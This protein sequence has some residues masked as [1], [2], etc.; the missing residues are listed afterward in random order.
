MTSGLAVFLL[1]GVEARR[2]SGPIPI[3]GLKMQAL[4][5]LLALS[6]P[7]PVTDDRLIDEIWGDERLSNPSNSLHSQVAMLRRAVG[8]DAVVRTGA[9]YTLAVDPDDVD[10]TRFASLIERAR[11]LARDGDV[12]SAAQGFQ[13][14]IGLVRG[15]PLRDLIDFPFGREAASRLEELLLE[16]HELRADAELAA[17]RHAGLVVPLT[18]LIRTHPLRERFHAQLIL[19]L[20]RC[21]RQ[22]D[23]LRAFSAARATLI[24][25]VGLEPGP[26]LRD[27]Q[28]AVLAHDP[29]LA[30]PVESARLI[31][32]PATATEPRSSEAGRDRLSR[33]PLVGRR[34]ELGWLRSDLDDAFSGRG[35]L[36]LLAGEPGIGKSRLAEEIADEAATRGATVAWGR[37]HRG[38][39]A[40]AFWPWTQVM[41]TLIGQFPVETVVAALG[42]R[43]ADVSQLVPD[44]HSLVPGLEPPPAL[45]PEFERFRLCD[46]LTRSIRALAAAQPLVVVLEDLH[47]ADASSLEMLTFLSDA[48]LEAPVLLVATYRDVGAR[49]TSTLNETLGDLAQQPVVRRLDVA[50][51]DV[52]DVRT[53]IATDQHESGD[54]LVRTVHRRTQGNPFFLVEILRLRSSGHGSDLGALPTG[55]RDVVRQRVGLLPDPTVDVMVAAA[56]LGSEFEL[57]TLAAS[58][59][60]S[61]GT[62]LQRLEPAIDARLI[63][64]NP[65]AP[66]RYA[67]SHALVRDTLY[68]QLGVAARAQWHRRAAEALET[69][70]G[71]VEG[72][73]LF[74]LA[75]HWFHA[76]PVA[77]PARGIDHAL[78]AARWAQR[79]VAHAQAEEQ[80]HNALALVDAMP[81]SHRRRSLELEVQH[82]LSRLLVMTQGYASPAVELTCRRMRT[83][84]ESVD[85]RRI[86]VPAL[87]RLSIFSCVSG[88][89]DT[90]HAIGEQL[91]ELGP[92]GHDESA[93]LAGHML[94]GMIQT[95]AGDQAAARRHI[96]AA[97]TMCQEGHD[98]SV[99]GFVAEV[100]AA[101]VHVCSAMN[102]ALLGQDDE[103]ERAASQA[104]AL[105][106]AADE[107]TNA[108]AITCA[109][110]FAS[111]VA[112]IRDDVELTRQRCEDGISIAS[113]QGY[114]MMF[115]PFL[116][117]HLG[118]AVAR[119]GEIDDG[120]AQIEANAS[121]VLATGAA[122]WR[123]VF[124]ALSADACLAG[125]R[126]ADA[127]D[128]ADRGLAALVPGGE[129]W[130]EAELHR[131]RGEALVG[132]DPSDP[133]VVSEFA[134]AIATAE[135]QGAR[136]FGQRAVAS[137]AKFP[138]PLTAP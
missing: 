95:R 134:A 25:E 81:D 5:A 55:V 35:R 2:P 107:G 50:G 122:M 135:R 120:L 102:L 103:A 65:D 28:A 80:L 112:T 82:E 88:D 23:A 94:L 60:E 11:E 119:E 39:G 97:I 116:A 14:A 36:V 71:A 68:E 87:W 106:T 85:D 128:H 33:P 123:H 20:Y 62:A 53:L 30:A 118:W 108:Y 19:A 76:V 78:R 72:P 29:A 51:L 7:G 64:T 109:V 130:Y 117:A 61:A 115:V 22:A 73:T 98:T 52:D 93:T 66:G 111:V 49:T 47:W 57:S 83:L 99:A 21:G 92:Q 13:T 6:A 114:G 129:R 12:R 127:L 27:L 91:C 77:D 69:I 38:R 44:V 133:R 45:G 58:L 74:A 100:P 37:C 125:G 10:A 16:A 41:Q 32:Q 96:D 75:D 15:A 63:T 24:D 1:G 34:A 31:H 90:A 26:E 79:H 40:P 113:A 3:P 101:W 42:Q 86:L 8:R 56:V 18:E 121:A 9:G 46:A 17:G 84:C 110:W 104:I 124:A 70:H 126:F 136:A 138:D 43:A 4:L 67:F 132:L 105:A 48:V 131:L 89:L 137:A 54:E 59:G